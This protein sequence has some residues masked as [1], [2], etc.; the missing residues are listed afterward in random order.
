[1]EKLIGLDSNGNVGATA[2]VDFS[3]AGQ[4]VSI[5]T[6]T[7]MIHQVRLVTSDYF[8]DFCFAPVRSP[9]STLS[10]ARPSSKKE[11]ISL[12]SGDR[13]LQLLLALTHAPF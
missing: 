6:P 12:L 1:V 9:Q 4:V 10:Q 7:P 13:V 2:N 8:D 3:L 5:S 11:T